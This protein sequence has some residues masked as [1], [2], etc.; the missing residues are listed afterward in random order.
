MKTEQPDFKPVYILGA[1]ASKMLGAPLVND[2]LTRALELRFSPNFR[3]GYPLHIEQK[4]DDIFRYQRELYSTRKYLGIDLDNIETLFSILDMDWATEK[5]N[6][7]TS[8]EKELTR[9]EKLHLLRDSFFTIII[10]T[11]NTS[12]ST[13]GQMWEYYRQLIRTLAAPQESCFITFNYDTSIEKALSYSDN[14]PD[15][16]AYS[17]KIGTSK[18]ELVRQPQDRFVLKLHGS[19]DWT[20]CQECKKFTIQNKG[21]LPCEFDSHRHFIHYTDTKTN[22]SQNQSK[23][24]N[25]LIPPTWNKLNYTD[26]IT[27]IWY[28]SIKEISC[29]TH[30]LIIGYSFPRTDVFFDQLLTLGLRDNKVLKQVAVIN[31]DQVL[32]TSLDS[33]FDKHF[34]KSKV[35]FIPASFQ[36]FR[37]CNIGNQISSKKHLENS[38][39]YFSEAI[40]KGL[41]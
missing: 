34:N 27:N 5:V 33:F 39:N 32:S 25:V 23:V 1:G 38:L 4:F 35:T 26:E 11:L 18:N 13:S 7:R 24:L 41:F 14:H 10:E 2:F 19:V 21:I 20:Y 6:E 22:C 30:L 28:H 37:D 17:A 12:I 16:L 3:Q 31:P 9:Y 36:L 29:A 8:E 15:D 40:K